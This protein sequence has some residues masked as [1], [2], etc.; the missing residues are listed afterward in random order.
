MQDEEIHSEIER[1]NAEARKKSENRDFG[2]YKEVEKIENT[3]IQNKTEE[4]KT[5]RDI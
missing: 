4:N 2:D 1:E 5:R 3:H